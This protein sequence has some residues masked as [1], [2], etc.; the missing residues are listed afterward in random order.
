MRNDA[1]NHEIRFDDEEY[2]FSWTAHSQIN[3]LSLKVWNNYQQ[4][5]APAAYGTLLDIYGMS[6]HAHNQIHFDA[7]SYT[8]RLRYAWYGSTAWSSWATFWNTNNDGSG[9]GLDADLVD[10]QHFSTTSVPTLGGLQIGT[11]SSGDNVHH[12]LQVGG[13]SNYSAIRMRYGATE[14]QQMHFFGPSWSS[15]FT[16]GSQGAINLSGYNGVTFGPWNA[17]AGYVDNSGN[18]GFR[19][20]VTAYAYSDI[21]LKHDVRPLFDSSLQKLMQLRGVR[22]DWDDEYVKSQHGD[23]DERWCP[24]HDVGMIAQEVQEVLPE[25][26]VEQDSGYLAVR[27]EKLIPLLVESIKELK[28]EVD[29]LKAQLKEK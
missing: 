15:S 17:P 4:T 27:Y 2:D 6:G 16:G 7:N 5:G 14:R 12:I 29:D 1:T 24:K 25:I 22:F 20:N 18:A 21:R 8:M 9:S 28:A 11:T 10:G 19:G 26:T 3:P 13:D 23:E